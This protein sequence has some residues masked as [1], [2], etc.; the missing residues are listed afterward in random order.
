[1]T[2]Q[3]GLFDNYFNELIY[4]GLQTSASNFGWQAS[5]LQSASRSDFLKNIEA[6]LG[7]DCNLVVSPGTLVEEIQIAAE[8]NP[9][10]KFMMLDF[11]FD[12]P[13]ENV[14]TQVYTTDQAAF[15]AGYV[16]ASVSKTGKV[17]VFGGVDI[18]Q[19]TD[20]MDGFALGVAYFNKQNGTTV[21]VIGW[22]AQK[23]VG[24]FM[25]GF[26]C[27]TEGRQMAQRLLDAGADIILPVAGESVGWGAG[28][29]VQ[30]HGNAY[31][32]GVDTDW[33]ATAPEFADI[34]LTS[35]EKRYDVS[36]VRAARSIVDGDFSGGIHTGTLETGEVGISPF[37]NLDALVSPAVKAELEKVKEGIIAG[38]IRT[39]P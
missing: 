7:A 12:P 34:L 16:A 28:A 20:F 14:W 2:N 27:T 17:G 29:E 21:E 24:L 36:V 35:I 19:V 10:Q 18:P 9:I 22:D 33:M 31:L 8:A 26:C 38:V 32:I 23:H 37:H 30:E 1:V 3:G 25:G 11:P 6:F 5:A 4:K 15:L 13:L 39:R